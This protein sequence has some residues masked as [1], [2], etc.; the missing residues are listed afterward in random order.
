MEEVLK[1]KNNRL[2]THTVCITERLTG[3]TPR[4]G[5]AL[6]PCPFH[7]RSC[8]RWRS[9]SCGPGSSPDQTRTSEREETTR[10][11]LLVMQLKIKVDLVQLSLKYCIHTTPTSISMETEFLLSCLPSFKFAISSVFS[12]CKYGTGTYLV[13][14]HTHLGSLQS[15]SSL[16]IRLG[17]GLGLLSTSGHDDY[18]KR[19]YVRVE[20]CE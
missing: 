10:S 13:V 5:N 7:T 2:V 6:Y 15:R 3:H 16:P 12:I 20:K 19:A 1:Y 14:S 11:S 8:T 4:G 9:R 17:G 18:D